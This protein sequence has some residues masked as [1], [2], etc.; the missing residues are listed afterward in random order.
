MTF[1]TRRAKKMISS[2]CF[3]PHS[4]FF[5]K[6]I[7]IGMFSIS[8]QRCCENKANFKKIGQTGS[9][10]M[11]LKNSNLWGK[12]FQRQ[13]KKNTY[14]SLEKTDLRFFSDGKEKNPLCLKI[15][16][17]SRPKKIK[18]DVILMRRFDQI[19]SWEGKKDSSFLKKFQP[20]AAKKILDVVD[21]G[22]QRTFGRWMTWLFQKEKVN[23]VSEFL[24]MGKCLAA[25][26]KCF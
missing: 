26:L 2:N 13:Q 20:H 3:F 25:Q 15:R 12:P 24:S 14:F 22:R 23:Q 11:G 5:N 1:R 6:M 10:L 8:P 9:R 7:S 4:C 17:S 18:S 16:D 21:E 19:L